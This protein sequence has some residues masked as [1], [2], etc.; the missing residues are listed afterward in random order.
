MQI[1][2]FIMPIDYNKTGGIV[3]NTTLARIL[4]AYW[5]EIKL[6]DVTIQFST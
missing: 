2:A 3:E 1:S 6:R 4:T 5:L